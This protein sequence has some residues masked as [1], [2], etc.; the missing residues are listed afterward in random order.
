MKRCEDSGLWVAGAGGSRNA[1]ED[2]E[3]EE[4]SEEEGEEEEAGQAG[5]EGTGEGGK[6]PRPPS[7]TGA[8][9]NDAPC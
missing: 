3:E 5:G 4:F 9:S 6:L 8:G 2:E 7:P 1:G